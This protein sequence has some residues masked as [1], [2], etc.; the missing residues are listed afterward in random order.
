MEVE[1]ETEGETKEEEED[2]QEHFDTFPTMKELRVKGLKV[3]VGN[4]TYEC[5]FMVLEDTTSVIDHYLGSV[6]F[7]KPFVEATGL[8]YNKEEYREVTT[9]FTDSNQFRNG[10]NVLGNELTKKRCRLSGKAP[11]PVDQ[12]WHDKKRIRMDLSAGVG[13]MLNDEDLHSPID[14]VD[15]FIFFMDTAK[16]FRDML[17][18]SWNMV[19]KSIDERAH[20]NKMDMTQVIIES[21]RTE[22]QKQD[23]SSRS[24]NDADIR[25]IYDEEPMKR[26][27]SQKQASRNFDLMINQMVSAENNT[28]GPFQASVSSSMTSDQNRSEPQNSNHSIEPSSSKVGSKVVP[29]ASRQLHHD[30]SWNYYSTI[31]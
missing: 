18:S 22:S 29:L 23:T 7:G 27:I 21:N 20:S 1:E 15:P 31:K 26:Q 24:G 19:K 2:D 3:F 4:F 13:I 8:V 11:L 6:V 28:S 10:I 16:E 12:S 30:K 14:E 9:I 25:P 5:D 17:V